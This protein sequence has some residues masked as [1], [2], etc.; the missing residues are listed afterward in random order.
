MNCIKIFLM[1]SCLVVKNFGIVF[2][3]SVPKSIL[4]FND[5]LRI[6]PKGLIL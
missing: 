6:I 3:Q 4:A 2:E 1:N 5:S